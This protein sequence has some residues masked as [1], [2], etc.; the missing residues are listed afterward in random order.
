[1]NL[2]IVTWNVR[3]LNDGAQRIRV[4][5]LLHLWK[6]DM[7]CLQETKLE[8]VSKDLVRSLWRCRYIDWICLDS[9]GASGG[10][11]LM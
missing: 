5:N 10:I 8:V 9:I 3:G 4:H 7:V 6:A 1:M 2:N 11:I